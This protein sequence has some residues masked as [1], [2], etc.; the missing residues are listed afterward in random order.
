MER[1]V[2]EGE[3]KNMNQAISRR[4]LFG[5]AGAAAVAAPLSAAG[6]SGP[7]EIWVGALTMDDLEPRSAQEAVD[8][9]LARMDQLAARKPDIV[10]LPETFPLAVVKPVPTYDQLAEPVPGPTTN[11][12]A[13]WARAHNCYVICPIHERESGRIYNTAVVLDRRGRIAGSYRK[14]H[15]V[16]AEMEAGA[17]CG[18]IA[19]AAIGTDFG[20][21]GIQ[22]CFDVNW[23]E[24][25][26]A[27]KRS[28]AEIVFWPSAYPGGRALYPLAWRNIFHIVSVPW[29]RPGVAELIDIS[30]DVLASSG[31]WEPWVCAPLN[32]EK[33]L[34]HTDLHI[35]KMRKLEAKYGRGVRVR[36]L[37][38][39]HWFTLEALAKDLTLAQLKSEFGLVPLD[40]YL[41]RADRAQREDMRS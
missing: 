12:M 17:S 23:P 27:L 38:L 11:R 24:D 13:E 22:I 7:R 36:W 28:G 37:H 10:C 2:S 34:F 19:P 32:L 35:E 15:V 16:E 5:L 4:E 1:A 31:R 25:W 40:E 3:N 20:R 29:C 9:A 39:E 6:R 21:I 18:R 33:G 14:I 30:G 41:A 26:A 8:L